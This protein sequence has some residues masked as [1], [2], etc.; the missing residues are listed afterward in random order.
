VKS[1]LVVCEGN[2]C[3]SPMGAGL[4]K[5]ALPR[6]NVQSAGLGALVGQPAEDFAVRLMHERAIDISHHRAVQ[7]TRDMCLQADL[8]LTMDND[9]RKRL[10]ERYPQAQGRI[11]RVGEHIRQDIPDPYRQSE[12]IFRISLGLLDAGVREWLK[13]IEKLAQASL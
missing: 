4:L 10:E 2:I 1:I 11:F 7:V 13:R 9:Q 3:R 12:S 5:R 6:T 8:V